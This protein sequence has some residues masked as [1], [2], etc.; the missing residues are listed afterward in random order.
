MRR[1]FVRRDEREMQP[2]DGYGGFGSAP[3]PP[4][5]DPAEVPADCREAAESEREMQPVEGDE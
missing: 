5:P 3:A 4:E 2:V 1:D